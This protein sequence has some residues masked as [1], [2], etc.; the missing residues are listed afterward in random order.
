MA[1]NESKVVD[2]KKYEEITKSGHQRTKTGEV[3]QPLFDYN[4]IDDYTKLAINDIVDVLENDKISK[5]Q[6]IDIIKQKFQLEEIPEYDVENS[7]WKNMMSEFKL[8]ESIQGYKIVQDNM[9]NKTKIP[10]LSFTGELDYLDN[11]MQKLLNR[12]KNMVKK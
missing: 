6:S 4:S 5:K 1:D 11:V 7:L 9:G 2:Q 8:G 12:I 10:V 3:I